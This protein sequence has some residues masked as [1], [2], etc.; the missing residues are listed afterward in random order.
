MRSIHD[1]TLYLTQPPHLFSV[2]R[3]THLPQTGIAAGKGCV[4]FRAAEESSNG[5]A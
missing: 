5:D 2:A 3:R 1:Y 4:L